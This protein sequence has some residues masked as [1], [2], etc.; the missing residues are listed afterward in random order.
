[1]TPEE[2]WVRGLRQD[3][4]ERTEKRGEERTSSPQGAGQ[5]LSGNDGS[6]V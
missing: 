4:K 5:Q 2:R 6:D 1:M 3:R